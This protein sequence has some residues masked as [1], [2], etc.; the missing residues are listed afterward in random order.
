MT[1]PAAFVFPQKFFDGAVFM[2]ADIGLM[3]CN[4]TPQKLVLYLKASPFHCRTLWN[5][6][7]F[8]CRF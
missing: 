4:F 5:G 2:F 8:P 1:W 7:K 6:Y 3:F